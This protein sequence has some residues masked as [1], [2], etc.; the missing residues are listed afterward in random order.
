M[1]PFIRRA[2]RKDPGNV[3]AHEASYSQALNDMIQRLRYCLQGARRMWHLN[4]Q[5]SLSDEP[6]FLKM[7]R[8]AGSGLVSRRVPIRGTALASGLVR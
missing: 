1:D 6:V 2:E 8:S 5:I 7:P 3:E 4:A